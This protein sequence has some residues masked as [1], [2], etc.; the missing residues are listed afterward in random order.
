MFVSVGKDLIPSQ[1]S[2]MEP[3][4]WHVMRLEV[5]IALQRVGLQQNF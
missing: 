1:K 2:S 3:L 4:F 5:S